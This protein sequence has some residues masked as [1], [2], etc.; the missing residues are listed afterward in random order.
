MGLKP[1]FDTKYVLDPGGYHHVRNEVI[2]DR[3]VHHNEDI[4]KYKAND[5]KKRRSSIFEEP[6]KFNVLAKDLGLRFIDAMGTP[7]VHVWTASTGF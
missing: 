1:D 2:G 7:V 4:W 5:Y 3:T 6:N